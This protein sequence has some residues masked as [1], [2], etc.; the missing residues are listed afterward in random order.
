VCFVYCWEQTRAGAAAEILMR[1][2]ACQESM[3]AWACAS[4]LSR[5]G[6][7]ERRHCV[8]RTDVLFL[9]LL[10]P[11]QHSLVLG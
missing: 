8:C 9:L 11:I 2:I 10:T 7:G 4:H 1:S 3:R 6:L 5:S